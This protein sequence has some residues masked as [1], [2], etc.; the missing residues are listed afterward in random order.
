MLA[1][2]VE[3][4][5]NHQ[6]M[7][8]EINPSDQ[9]LA[10]ISLEGNERKFLRDALLSYILKAATESN[11]QISLDSPVFRLSYLLLNSKYIGSQVIT[12]VAHE[13]VEALREV[14]ADSARDAAYEDAYEM[15]RFDGQLGALAQSLEG[16][17]DSPCVS[18][19]SDTAI[20]EII[21][22]FAIPDSPEGLA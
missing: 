13:H 17:T 10:N 9:S 8:Y 2:E 4:F 22:G 21:A 7:K 5:Y 20:E 18:T 15:G 3:R 14:L 6:R 16:D 12:D 11:M 1:V 19:F